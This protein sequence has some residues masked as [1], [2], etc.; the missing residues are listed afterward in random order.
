VAGLVTVANAA[1]TAAKKSAPSLV[2]FPSIQIEH[3]YGYQGNCTDGSCYDSNYA[4]IASLPRDRFAMS[5]YPELPG[6]FDTPQQ[7]PSDWLSRGAMRGGER[8]LIAETGWSST[9]LVAETSGGVCDTVE[10]STEANT[11]AYLAFV[12]KSAQSMPMDLVD[13]WD[14]RDLVVTQ[15]MTNCPCTFDTTW[16]EVLQ[17]FSGNPVD[18]GTDTY[19]FGQLELKAFGAMGLRDYMGNPKP[20]TFPIW[21]SA[22]ALPIAP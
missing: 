5:S 21:Q 10:T 8:A 9:P 19:F 20:T 16:C 22:L 6:V 13:W 3:L 12:L 15:L 1:Y 14:D 2:V 18:S 17:A 4:Q 7:V 11:A